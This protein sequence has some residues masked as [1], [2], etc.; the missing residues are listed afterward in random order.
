LKRIV[1]MIDPAIEDKVIR[2]ALEEGYVTA[3]D[4]AERAPTEPWGPRL[5]ALVH[6]GLL[7]EPLIERLIADVGSGTASSNGYERYN[8]GELLG[9][10]GMGQ[11]YR[12]YDTALKRPV[13][14]KFLRSDD[15]DLVVRFL[16]EAQA[17]ARVDHQN[18]CKVYEVGELDGRPYIA[19]QLIQGEA[20][21]SP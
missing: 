6:S 2:R 15:P 4:V 3:Q 16:R 10:G 8:R 5:S 14:L 7:S 18:V 17:Q 11:V 19:M 20:L 13:A 21:P 9:E 1:A 12:A